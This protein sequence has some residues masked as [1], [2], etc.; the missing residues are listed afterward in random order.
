MESSNA[1]RIIPTNGAGVI[2]TLVTNNSYS[3]AEYGFGNLIA[4]ME[5]LKQNELD[6]QAMQQHVRAFLKDHNINSEN[7][8]TSFETLSDTFREMVFMRFINIF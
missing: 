2:T 1:G 8:G 6:A 7:V 3:E 4:L 5:E